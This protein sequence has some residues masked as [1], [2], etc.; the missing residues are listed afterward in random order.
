MN[1]FN[2]QRLSLRNPKVHNATDQFFWWGYL[3][4]EKHTILIYIWVEISGSHA[5]EYDGGCLIGC[6]AV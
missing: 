1:F 5:G 6:S 2:K 4:L 3:V